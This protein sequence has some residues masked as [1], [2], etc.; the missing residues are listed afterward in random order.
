MHVQYSFGLRELIF[1]KQTLP[2]VSAKMCT[3]FTPPSVCPVDRQ[4]QQRRTAGLL[5]SWGAGSRYRSI[6][7]GARAAAAA[8]SSAGL[9]AEQGF[10]YSPFRGGFN[11]PYFLWWRGTVVERRSLA[12]E[13]SLSCARL[14][15]DG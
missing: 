6:A 4:Q 8:T 10:F 9:R 5:L 15:A 13:L 12:G 1:Y 14:A 2:P 3:N 11:T 7:A